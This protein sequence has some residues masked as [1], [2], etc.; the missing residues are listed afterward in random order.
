MSDEDAELSA[1]FG[2]DKVE[3]EPETKVDNE[4]EA[5]VEDSPATTAETEQTEA[6]KEPEK[7]DSKE[8]NALV[9][10][11]ALLDERRKRQALEDRLSVLEK[12]VPKQED[13]APDPYRDLDKYNEFQRK[14]WER[15]QI[16][17]SRK[18]RISKIEKR[19]TELLEQNPD[20]EEAERVFEILSIRDPNLGRELMESPDPVSFAY[21]KGRTY[22][23]EVLSPAKVLSTEMLDESEK[24]SKKPNLAKATAGA[25]NKVEVDNEP[26]LKGVF[27]DQD[28]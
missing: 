28:Y 27:A 7:K 4:P 10:K 2:E 5:K 14:K 9:P 11:A 17:N 19:R 16:E 20:F 24:P 22:I 1:F 13:E 18:E 6:S 12:L 21:E 26:T 8:S 25:T 23:K 3:A 15:E